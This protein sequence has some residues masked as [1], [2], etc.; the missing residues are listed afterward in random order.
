MIL[1]CCCKNNDTN[2]NNDD[3]DIENDNN[4]DIISSK[5][6][7]LLSDYYNVRLIKEFP[8]CIYIGYYLK[9]NRIHVIKNLYKDTK[10]ELDILLNLKHEAIIEIIDYKK[11]NNKIQYSMLKYETDLMDYINDHITNH[12]IIS[13]I[14]IFN[15]LRQIV[16]G[17]KYLHIDNEICHRDIKPENIVLNINRPHLCKIIDFGF[18]KKF[19][20][21]N[22][23]TDEIIGTAYYTAPEIVLEAFCKR[24]PYDPFKADIYAL[25]VSVYIMCQSKY[26]FDRSCSN[27]V[28]TIRH[29]GSNQ[30]KRF[31]DNYKNTEI[32]YKKPISHKLETFINS[33][34]EHNYLVRPTIEEVEKL[35]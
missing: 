20:N 13:E 6:N 25:G 22:A 19:T 9:D 21:T 5:K 24:K 30:K 11:T 34:L 10:E 27:S 32:K 2:L 33:C 26:P 12:K 35:L 29:M 17:L 16:S 18:A 1:C 4:E 3:S 28:K 23:K 7:S 31:I 15:I 8:S 14:T